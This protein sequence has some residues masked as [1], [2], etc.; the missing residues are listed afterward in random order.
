MHLGDYRDALH[1]AGADYHI[2]VAVEDDGCFLGG[3][4]YVDDSFSSSDAADALYTMADIRFEL[5]SYG[6]NTERGFSLAMAAL[7]EDLTGPGGCNEGFLRDRAGLVVIHTSD[8][9]EQST[10]T[11]ETYVPWLLGLKRDPED[12]RVHVGFGY[13]GASCSTALTGNGYYEAAEATGGIDLTYC[14]YSWGEPGVSLL[15]SV[16][17]MQ[18]FAEASVLQGKSYWLEREPVPETLVVRVD[19]VTFE[20]WEWE[21]DL[22]LLVFDPDHLPEP[23]STVEIAYRPVEDCEP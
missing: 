3:H 9:P 20:H 10:F 6:S 7:D 22:G 11:W 12:V 14:G 18:R 17:A 4:T 19:G 16:E 1:E 13:P 2:A 23:G 15:T 8:E 21:P 5:G